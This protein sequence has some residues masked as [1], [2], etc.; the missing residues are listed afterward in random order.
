[1]AG[2][3]P[4][5]DMTKTD[6][7][8]ELKK[9]VEEWKLHRMTKVHNF[10]E[11]WQ[12]SQNLCTI[13]KESCTQ[14]KQMIPVGHIS[15]MKEIV[16]VSWSL[17]QHDNVAAFQLLERSTLTPA[18]FAKDIPGGQNEIFNVHRIR[19]INCYQVAGDEECMH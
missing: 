17:F 5:L 7:H 2:D 12:G 18:L 16:R 4:A 10:L 3:D 14:I 6:N 9:V 11:M 15:D 1:L 8:L 13:Q 19:T